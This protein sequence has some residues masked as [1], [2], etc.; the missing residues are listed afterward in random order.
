VPSSP[1]WA[2]RRQGR[3]TAF[4]EMTGPAAVSCFPGRHESGVLEGPPPFLSALLS[5]SPTEDPWQEAWQDVL[6]AAGFPALPSR[7]RNCL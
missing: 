3:S 4:L 5:L 2:A 6:L 7:M 1:P